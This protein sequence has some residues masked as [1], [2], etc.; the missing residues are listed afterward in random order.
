MIIYEICPHCDGENKFDYINDNDYLHRCCKECG[1]VM[2]LCGEC[3][4][5]NSIECD[6]S[7]NSG[8]CMMNIQGGSQK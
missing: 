3:S 1:K 4:H 6:W 5:S 7:A 8:C 2:M